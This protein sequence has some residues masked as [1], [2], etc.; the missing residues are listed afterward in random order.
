[1]SANYGKAMKLTSYLILS[2]IVFAGCAKPMPKTSEKPMARVLDHYLYKSDLAGII[3]AGITGTDSIAMVRDFKERWIR[4]QLLLNKAELNLTDD[5]KNVEQQMESYRS[6]LLIYAYEQSYIRQHL[7]TVV[8]GAE[9]ENFYKENQSNFILNGA[10]MKGVFIKIP[11]KSPD[12]YKVR[13]WYRSDVPE[14]IKNLEAYCFKYATVYDH[15]N[16]GWVKLNEVLPMI[17]AVPG[18][19]E[20]SIV[21]R[22]YIETR[23]TAFLYFLNAKEI[24]A[25]GNVSPLEIVKND[26]ESIIL[27]KRKISL[28]NELESNIYSDAQNRDHFTIYK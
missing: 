13:Q 26:I 6:S 15:F 24:A 19:S 25:S 9:I 2:V 3:P 27:N 16:D 22:R 23:D 10:L 7:D 18:N 28:I 1:M 8:T 4:N 5:E 17:P 12:S 14:N 21:S 11:V 20:S